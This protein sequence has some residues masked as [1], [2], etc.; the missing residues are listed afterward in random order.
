MA[1]EKELLERGG[2]QVSQFIRK[3]EEIQSMYDILATI[4]GV[5]FSR[6]TLK[7]IADQ[8]RA[9]SPDVVHVHNFFPLISPGI[10]EV[11]Q[12]LGVP[13]VFTLHNY[14]IICPT[15]QFHWKG[16]LETRSLHEGPWWAV[17]Q[18]VYKNSYV[19]SAA[20]AY[21]IHR[22]KKGNYW[23]KY[24]SKFIAL[25]NCS[26][27]IYIQFGINPEKIVVKQNFVRRAQKKV[28]NTGNQGSY[29]LYV[30]RLA[31]EKGIETLLSAWEKIGH[32]L[33]LKII[34]SGPLESLVI[35]RQSSYVEYLGYKNSSEVRD[36]MRQAAVTVIPS[37]C[38]EGHPLVSIE[39]F[40]VGT[41]IIASSIG[42][43]QELVESSGGGSLFV[44]GSAES[45]AK[46]V[47]DLISEK[48]IASLGE[49]AW[50]YYERHNTPEINLNQLEQIYRSVTH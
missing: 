15:A 20:L 44:P 1:L 35:S 33:P 22:G 39:S 10:F 2:H 18:K 38:H 36:L 3:S 17:L 41:P 28:E 30:G 26:R 32:E 34:G 24:V 14:R 6:R 48:E 5:N 50:A 9:M 40:S 45:L 19:G 42:T 25:S 16:R 49:R 29:A 46:A 7:D 27:D 47:S 37:I 4:A 23:N 31:Q 21:M 8:I 11:C 13:V 43:L 12:N